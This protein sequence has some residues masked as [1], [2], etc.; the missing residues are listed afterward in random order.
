[1]KKYEDLS[2]EEKEFLKKSQLSISRLL[3]DA[4][5][6]SR[7]CKNMDEFTI[8]Q[9]I[10]DLYEPSQPMSIDDF[11]LNYMI[12]RNL[13]ADCHELGLSSANFIQVLNKEQEM[14]ER[15]ELYQTFLDN[16]RIQRSA[17]E[18]SRTYAQKNGVTISKS[19][20]IIFIISF[21]IALLTIICNGRLW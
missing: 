7:K 19:T 9:T 5:N 17:D 14:F 6:I 2:Q 12:C 4:Y 1:M 10:A 15:L 3:E 20:L 21:I 18:V 11:A 8:S 13:I 16:V